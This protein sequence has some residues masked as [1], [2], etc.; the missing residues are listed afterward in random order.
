MQVLCLMAPTASGKTALA[1]ELAA[2]YPVEI[3]SVDSAMVYT[4]MD[5]GTAKPSADEL[6]SAP[7]HLIDIIDPTLSY[8]AGQFCHDAERL[9]QQIHGRGKVP[10]LVGGTCLYFHLFQQGFDRFIGQDPEIYQ[11]VNAKAK[12]L[13]WP[14]MHQL[15]RLFDPLTAAQLHP[16]DAQRISRAL[17]VYYASGIPLSQHKSQQTWSDRSFEWVNIALLP[18]DRSQLHARIAE[19]F[20]AMMQ[21]GFI[22]EVRALFERG[23]LNPAMPS[24]KLVGYRQAWQYLSGQLTLDS[25][26]YQAICATRQLAKRQ[27]TWLRKWPHLHGFDPLSSHCHA[28]IYALLDQVLKV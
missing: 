21:A 22:Q 15:L 20:S 14:A 16:N 4:H 24:M 13:G 1:I 19:R 5:I 7:H 6:Q 10:L 18:S 3:I 2:R 28:R 17:S 26:Q 23:D 8:S 9:C 12:H 27:F 11:Q 25:M